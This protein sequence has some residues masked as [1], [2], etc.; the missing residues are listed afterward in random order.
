MKKILVAVVLGAMALAMFGSVALAAG[1]ADGRGP[2]T[3]QTGE[4]LTNN[5]SP[6]HMMLNN[7]SHRSRCFAN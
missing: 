7:A 3:A 4:C 2:W 5:G 1:P 6:G